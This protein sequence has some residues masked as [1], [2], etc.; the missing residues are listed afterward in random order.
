MKKVKLFALF[1]TLLALL[2]WQMPAHA[3][4]P[5]DRVKQTVDEVIDILKNQELKK[6]VNEAKRRAAIRQAVSREFNFEEMAKRALAVHWKKR[7]PEE[8]REFV[9]LFTDLLER[10]Y[11]RKIEKYTEEKILYVG[12]KTQ[13]DYAVV[14]T[15][16]TKKNV[17]TPIQYKLSKETGTWMVYDVVI[18]GVSLVNN[19]R[20]QFNRIIRENSYEE[21]V[22][23]MKAKGGEGFKE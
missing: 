11:I 14:D 6:P 9:Q 16:V 21:L 5:T 4:V 20:N 8:R 15:K 7:T 2:L 10:S 12:E 13:G 23:K 22:R 18:E 1:I 19:Y 17:E 3:G